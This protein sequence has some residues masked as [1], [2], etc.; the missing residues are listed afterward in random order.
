MLSQEKYIAAA[1][2]SL[3]SQKTSFKY[4]ILI[5]DDNST[6]NTFEICKHYKNLYPDKI[7]VFRNPNNIGVIDNWID[8]LKKAAGKYIAV[9][10]GDDFWISNDKLEK[11]VNIL[12]NNP[13][14]AICYH[15][16]KEINGNTNE[17]IKLSN[18]EYKKISTIYDLA[19]NNFIYNVSCIYRNLHW[20]FP[21]WINSNLPTID[22][23]LHLLAALHGDIYFIED[24]MAVYRIHDKSV[25]G[26]K[27]NISRNILLVE[28]LLL[29]IC[30][31]FNEDI[32]KII[33]KQLIN[34]YINILEEII[35]YENN[36]EVFNN[37]FVQITQIVDSKIILDGIYSHIK[38][39][40]NIYLQ[41]SASRSYKLGYKI[42][43]PFVK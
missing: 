2:E 18:Q 19:E 17:L 32:N 29:P 37:I 38:Y 24:C 21:N 1:I 34:Y 25:W 16:V 39:F 5:N 30:D 26:G 35:D 27:D 33:Q 6:D 40:K 22:Y 4:E 9:C 14:I 28:K 3:V 13:N 12:E 31:K 43:H 41:Y 20:N 42:L 15:R 10:E 11:Q 7:K 8:I 36:I 23:P